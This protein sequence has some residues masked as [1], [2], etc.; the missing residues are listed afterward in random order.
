MTL[1]TVQVCPICSSDHLKPLMIARDYTVTQGDFS[2]QQCEQC[3]FV[4]TSPRPDQNSI[5]LYYQSDK[6]ISHTSS[7]KNVI[8]RIYLLARNYTLRSKYKLIKKY[9]ALGSVLDYGCGTG[10]FLHYIQKRNWQIAGVEPSE[11]AAKK[12]HELTRTE[13]YH[14]L[15]QINDKFDVITL[16]HVLEHVHDLNEKLIE[17]KDHLEKDGILLVAVPNYKSQDAQKYGAFW[18]GFDVPRHLW[19]FSNS[20]MKTLLEKNGFR[21]INTMPM[22]L[23]SYYV[24]LLS[25][26]YKQPKK[27]TILRMISA[28]LC[29]LSSNNSARRTGQYSSLIY[30]ARQS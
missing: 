11:A 17:I 4:A 26:S 9:K 5:A 20:T 29:G 28:F 7:G 21:L 6:Y 18:A 27:A 19:H 14:D 23:D 22:K 12:A 15:K 8:D 25:E 16:W 10:A 13:I 3:H 1:E 30:I 2:L 24:S